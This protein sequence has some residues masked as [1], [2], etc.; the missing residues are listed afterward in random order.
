MKGTA[1]F[2]GGEKTSGRASPQ[3]ESLTKLWLGKAEIF[4]L[5]LDSLVWLVLGMTSTSISTRSKQL[6]I[7]KSGNTMPCHH[8]DRRRSVHRNATRGRIQKRKSNRINSSTVSDPSS[9]AHN[10]L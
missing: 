9:D 4:S 5:I 6:R 7:I 2:R 3:T 1:D 10:N 8:E